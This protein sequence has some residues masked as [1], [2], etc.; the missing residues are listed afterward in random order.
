[1]LRRNPRYRL[2][3]PRGLAILGAL[4]LLAGT[5]TGLGGTHR[6]P[7]AEPGLAAASYVPSGESDATDR[8]ADPVESMHQ[9]PLRKSK[10]F[11]VNLFLFRR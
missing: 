7:E 9:A 6:H 10:R 2:Q 8:V 3:I 4:L 11:K 5:V 1:M